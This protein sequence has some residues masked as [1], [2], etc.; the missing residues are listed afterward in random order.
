MFKNS[1]AVLA[2]HLSVGGT[3]GKIVFAK[4]YMLDLSTMF[5]SSKIT[6]KGAITPDSKNLMNKDTKLKLNIDS[7][8]SGMRFSDILEII[9]EQNCFNDK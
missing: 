4:D 1:G 2:P 3:N 9:K 7:A 8:L 5:K 6:L